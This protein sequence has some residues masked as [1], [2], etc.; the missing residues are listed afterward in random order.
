MRRIVLLISPSSNVSM[1]VF[2]NAPL[3]DSC[4]DELDVVS[5]CVS[6]GR[7]ADCTCACLVAHRQEDGRSTAAE[8]AVAVGLGGRNS[9]SNTVLASLMN[10]WRGRTCGVVGERDP[11]RTCGEPMER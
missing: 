7:Q 10:G 5:R 2:R 3:S 11:E 1:S 8:T 4:M 6:I 9:V